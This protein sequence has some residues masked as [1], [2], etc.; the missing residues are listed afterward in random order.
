MPLPKNTPHE[1]DFIHFW[2]PFVRV[3]QFLCISHHGLFRPELK[4]QPIKLMLH[5]IFFLLYVALQLFCAYLYLQLRLKL[6]MWAMERANVSP[7]FIYTNAGIKIIQTVFFLAIPCET[8][9]NRRTEQKLFETFQCVDDIFQKKLNYSIDYGLHWRRQW[10]K[11]LL[12]IAG[13][14]SA[15]ISSLSANVT[16]DQHGIFLGIVVFAYIFA[17]TRLRVFQIVFIINALYDLLVELK[18]MMR[19]QQHRVKY[20]AAHWKDIQ[21]AR[22]IY[23]K[24]WLLKT[25]IGQCFGYSMVLFVIDSAVKIIDTAYWFYLN[26]ES[27]KSMNFTIRKLNTHSGNSLQKHVPHLKHF[28]SNPV[29]ELCFYTMPLLLTL[30]YICWLSHQCH[31]AVSETIFGTRIFKLIEF[32]G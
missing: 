10:G 9:F 2:K 4:D 13:I 17:V 6:R 29:S 5:R 20:N 24:I 28:S 26:V 3:F 30:F 25:L 16:L 31:V 12:F 21:Y 15:F 27:I 14:T 11:Y 8:F 23:S 32:S 22:N 7:I 18:I 1:L 19:R